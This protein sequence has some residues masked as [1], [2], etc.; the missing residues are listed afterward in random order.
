MVDNMHYCGGYRE[1]WRNVKGCEG[2]VGDIEIHFVD[3]VAPGYFWIFPVNDDVANV[4]IG[5][6]IGLLKKEKKKLKA[7]QKDVIE[8]HPLFKERFADAEMSRVVVKV[9]IPF[10]SPRKKEAN[11]PL[12][13]HARNQIGWGFLPRWWILFPVKAASVML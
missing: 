11:Q 1:Y 7:L 8:N 10:G 12:C 3:S 9:G 13:Q 5:M 4:G 2:G 6:V